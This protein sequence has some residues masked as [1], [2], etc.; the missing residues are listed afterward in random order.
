MKIEKDRRKK[1]CSREK[2]RI[3]RNFSELENKNDCSFDAAGYLSLIESD[4]VN[5]CLSNCGS[6][7]EAS[8]VLECANDCEQEVQLG[9]LI[10]NIA[11]SK[12]SNPI[13]DIKVL[14][15]VIKVNRSSRVTF[16]VRDFF[17][18]WST[19]FNISQSATACAL[20]FFKNFF[21]DIPVDARTIL[22]TMRKVSTIEVPPGIY[23]H[24]GIG[25][26][27]ERILSIIFWCPTSCFGGHL[28]ITPN[29]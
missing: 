8:I 18:K 26:A 9:N 28:Q 10:E 29:Q 27:V 13:E 25:K 17:Q 23:S 2:K 7:S 1:R 20:G 4:N 14:K 6:D 15:N 5:N 22:H 19:E 21:P 11:V 16:C 24:C 3:L 12:K